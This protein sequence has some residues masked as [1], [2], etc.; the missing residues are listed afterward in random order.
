MN[1]GRARS[2][3]P[4][5]RSHGPSLCGEDTRPYYQFCEL[6]VDARQGNQGNVET[7]LQARYP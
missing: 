6:R 1:S 5:G 2:P 7:F 4:V 3:P